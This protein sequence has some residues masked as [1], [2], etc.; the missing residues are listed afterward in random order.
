M[1]VK[2]GL[3]LRKSWYD[4]KHNLIIFL[5]LLYAILSMLGL[6]IL[7]VLEYFLFRSLGFNLSAIESFNAGAITF[8]VVIG[9]IDL[10]ILFVVSYAIRAMYIGLLNGITTKKKATAQDMWNGMR[11]FT[12]LYL[13]VALVQ[14]LLIFV[15]LIVAGAII[16]GGFLINKVT[17]IIFAFL[18]GGIYALYLIAVLVILYFGLFFMGPIMS[19]GKTKSAINL[20]KE[21]LKYTKNNLEHMLLTWVITF[22]INMAFSIIFRIFIV[23]S[24]FFI[25]ILIPIFVITIVGSIILSAWLQIFVFNAYFNAGLKKL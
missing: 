3:L 21:S 8:L 17:G 19:L 6:G 5:P 16:G 23:S 14:F 11:R 15:P 10:V 24:T 25:F 9:L 20:I 7:A 18:F 2:Y 13:K 22:G 4:L 12:W 1:E